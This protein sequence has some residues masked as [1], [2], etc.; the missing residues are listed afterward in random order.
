[1]PHRRCV[2]TEL[3]IS[4]FTDHGFISSGFGK[5]KTSVPGAQWLLS[6]PPFI[7][8]PTPHLL[9]PTMRPPQFSGALPCPRRWMR[10]RGEHSPVITPKMVV[11]AFKVRYGYGHCNIHKR[12][13]QNTGR[14]VKVPTT[15]PWVKEM[16]KEMH[17]LWLSVAYPEKTRR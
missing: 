6:I 12:K 11:R 9:H 13:K 2:A 14:W 7:L 4:C 5:P 8:L 3:E 10:Y 17:G 16:G 15:P 1:M